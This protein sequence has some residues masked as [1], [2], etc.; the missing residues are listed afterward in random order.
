MAHGDA[1]PRRQLAA[2]PDLL[3]ADE[4]TTALDV[5]I[6][7]QVLE[8]LEGLRDEL[9]LSVL[10]ITHDLGI[11]AETCDRVAVMS[12]GR[13]VE[14]GPVGELFAHPQHEYTRALFAAAPGRNWAFA[15]DGRASTD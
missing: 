12:E 9:G 1:D 11:V 2:G 3:L 5:T 8:L 7:A 15:S 4:P 6:Q 13:I 10:L 14:E